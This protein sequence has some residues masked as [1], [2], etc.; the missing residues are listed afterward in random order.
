[1]S[2]IRNNMEVGNIYKGVAQIQYVYKGNR[3]IYQLEEGASGD[4]DIVL[5]FNTRDEKSY[6]DV[7]KVNAYNHI[8]KV[9]SETNTTT[10][11][12]LNYGVCHLYQYLEDEPSTVTKFNWEDISDNF[13]FGSASLK[14]AYS[15]IFG[16][17]IRTTN[18]V[19]TISSP[20]TKILKM[21]FA[22]V[23]DIKFD[24]LLYGLGSTLEYIRL[25]NYDETLRSSS[26]TQTPSSTT[27]SRL[28]HLTTIE[29][30][31]VKFNNT[32]YFNYSPLN[33]KSV[34]FIIDSLA[35]VTKKY[36]LNLKSSSYEYLSQEDIAL[37]TSKGWTI[38][39]K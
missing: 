25:E 39:S 23:Q 4:Y 36:T 27:S 13:Y 26:L 30:Y 2:I 22:K 16:Y 8:M 17:K 18:S 11:T 24:S 5:E 35:N 32:L 6:S 28:S 3:L 33:E 31:N 7:L 29:G 37:A 14:S 38:T 10:S 9:S 12:Q 20:I 1:M 15:P 34:K 21:D 19:N